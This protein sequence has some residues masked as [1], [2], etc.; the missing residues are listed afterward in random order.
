M[1]CTVRLI[2]DVG[3]GTGIVDKRA[4]H[5]RVAST[6]LRCQR[7]VDVWEGVTII[8][9]IPLIIHISRNDR[10][11]DGGHAEVG[12]FGNHCLIIRKDLCCIGVVIRP[13]PD[14]LIGVRIDDGRIELWR[15]RRGDSRTR[16]VGRKCDG[17]AAYSQNADNSFNRSR[18]ADR[19][20]P[21]VDRWTVR[22][23]GFITNG[24]SDGNSG[25]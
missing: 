23:D 22:R 11:H 3:R 10:K 17:A 9:A 5:V 21:A 20:C 19:Q 4:Q 25:A 1:V 12:A 13:C 24:E 15:T 2:G 18:F 6:E 16:K 8:P 14:G 7:I